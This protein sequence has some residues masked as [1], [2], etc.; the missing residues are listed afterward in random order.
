MLITIL[1]RKKSSMARIHKTGKQPY[2]HCGPS[3]R[4][5]QE[6]EKVAEIFFNE[7]KN[8]LYDSQSIIESTN[9]S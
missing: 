6:E 8:I 4:V 5:K 9:I 7:K 1:E 3:I 2:F